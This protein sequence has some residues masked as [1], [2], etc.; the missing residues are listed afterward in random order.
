MHELHE[1]FLPSATPSGSPQPPKVDQ[2]LTGAEA[3]TRIPNPRG[4]SRWESNTLHGPWRP[5][6]KALSSF[7]GIATSDMG[8]KMGPGSVPVGAGVERHSMSQ[9]SP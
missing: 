8:L 2:F 6:I 1:P 4:A 9:I 3:L 7:S 5:S